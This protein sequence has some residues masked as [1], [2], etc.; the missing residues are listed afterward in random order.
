LCGDKQ[1]INLRHDDEYDI[2][3]SV[4]ASLL[5][6]AEDVVEEHT[7]VRQVQLAHEQPILG[8]LDECFQLYTQD[9]RV[10]KSGNYHILNPV[11]CLN[12]VYASL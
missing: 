7:S 11:V 5:S 2:L 6:S 4:F 8:T 3:S 12:N 1:N 10:I 9:E